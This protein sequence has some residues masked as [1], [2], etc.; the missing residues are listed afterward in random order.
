M[1][2]LSV[3]DQPT[4]FPDEVQ[5]RLGKYVYR[6]VDPRTNETFYVGK[7]TGN[8]VFEH[9][10]GEIEPDPEALLPPKL[11][12]IRQIKAEGLEVVHLIHRHGLDDNQAFLVEA[13]LI[14][15]YPNL[16]NAVGGHGSGDTGLMTTREV[17]IKYGL[18]ELPLNPSHR[19][20][21]INIRK[22]SV[23]ESRNDIY[24]LV[25]YCWRINKAR[26]EQAEYVLAVLRG[27]VLGAYKAHE[28]LPATPENFLPAIPYADGSEAHRFG[29]KGEEAPN[30]IWELYVGRYGKRITQAELK[31]DQ[32][33]IRYWK[34]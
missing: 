20:V 8:R 33:P 23:R 19:L 18:P 4:F 3:A 28:W 13:S 29:F 1:S 7:G 22:L 34:C 27:V 11:D 26:A 24:R 10:R 15:A 2:A 6:L 16:T 12:T 14:D 21:L 25:R 9:A 30:D 32:Y 17:M 31:H 5:W